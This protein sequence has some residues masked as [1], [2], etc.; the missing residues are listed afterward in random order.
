MLA[1]ALAGA[2]DAKPARL[3]QSDAGGV[4]REDPGLDRPVA[5]RVRPLE[6]AGFDALFLA[7]VLG[8]YDVYG[9]SRDAAVR[10][11]AQVPLGDPMLPVPARIEPASSSVPVTSPVI[12]AVPSAPP[13]KPPE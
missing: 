2:D 11:G 1:N 9:G 8:I 7:D 12:F 13:I 3:V 10:A 5:G 6:D 4:L